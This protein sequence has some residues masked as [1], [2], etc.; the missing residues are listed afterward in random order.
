MLLFGCQEPAPKPDPHYVL[1]SPYQVDGV[2][3]YPSESYSLNETGLASVLPDGKP[4]LTTDGETFDQTAMAAAHPTLQLPAIARITNLENGLQ[5]T[6]RLNDRGTGD[7]GRLVQVTRRAATLLGM[8]DNGIARVRLEVLQTESRLAADALPGAPDLHM[9]TAPRD[10]VQVAQLAPPPGVAQGRGRE[11]TVTD[12]GAAP[13]FTSGRRATVA[14]AGNGHADRVAAGCA[15]D[16]ARCL[17]RTGLRRTTA[18]EDGG[19]RR[20]HRLL[21]ERAATALPGGDRADPGCCDG[22][23]TLASGLRARDT[24]RTYRGGL[25][26]G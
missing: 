19:R 16:L 14:P 20:P 23:F 11:V 17:S 1:G 21:P 26:G 25:T 8:P 22:G 12:A 3:F 2:W 5:V 7:P 9:T 4:R 13:T 10:A 15:D 6:V 18:G 24:G